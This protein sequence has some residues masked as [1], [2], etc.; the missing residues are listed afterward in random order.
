[1]HT[2]SLAGP[3]QHICRKGYIVRP[4][5]KKGLCTPTVW[6]GLNN[7]FVEKDTL[8]AQRAKKVYAHLRKL[9]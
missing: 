2:Y 3:K 1:M 6:Q 4:K 7:I 5:G 8:Y 9:K